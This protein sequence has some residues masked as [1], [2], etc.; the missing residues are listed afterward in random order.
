MFTP[1]PSRPDVRPL[2]SLTT[3]PS[4]A[5]GQSVIGADLKLYGQDITIVVVGHLRVDG[6]I[7]GH[8]YAGELT[9]GPEAQISGVV[10]AETLVVYGRLTNCEV[11]ANKVALLKGAY[12][13][14]NLNNAQIV[15][16]EGA[17]FDGVSRRRASGTPLPQ[18][19]AN[20]EAPPI[21]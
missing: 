10:V 12:V 6:Q 19:P 14:G 1:P 5:I 4:K 15:V 17:Y 2:Q 8:L 11:H 21:R 18:P 13:E 20:D 16:E 3:S 9:V 7:A